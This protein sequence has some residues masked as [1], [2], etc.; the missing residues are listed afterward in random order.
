[1]HLN[2]NIITMA[3]D[4]RSHFDAYVVLQEKTS[5]LRR[6][7]SKKIHEH[8][9]KF[10]VT[11]NLRSFSVQTTVPQAPQ[12]YNHDMKASSGKASSQNPETSKSEVPIEKSPPP[13]CELIF[14]ANV[15]GEFEL[16]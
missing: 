12:T 5:E 3:R 13:F 11:L 10:N 8:E 15:I 7:K 2:L 6:I 1:M 14:T 4:A 9:K 16:R